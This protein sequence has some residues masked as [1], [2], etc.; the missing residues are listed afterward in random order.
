VQWVVA[1]TSDGWGT[2]NAF[3]VQWMDGVYIERIW[4][5]LDRWGKLDGWGTLK[6]WSAL[7][8]VGKLDGWGTLN[9]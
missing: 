2:M 6:G 3:G 4:V 8:R 1:V 5:K 7:E 9:G